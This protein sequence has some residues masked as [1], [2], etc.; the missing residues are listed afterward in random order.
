MENYPRHTEWPRRYDMRPEDLVRALAIVEAERSRSV[1]CAGSI[2]P[3]IVIAFTVSAI[4]GLLASNTALIDK[5][6]SLVA[7]PTPI[8]RRPLARPWREPRRDRVDPAMA[9]ELR[10]ARDAIAAGKLRCVAG[11]VIRDSG[12]GESR[13]IENVTYRGSPLTCR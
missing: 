13:S 3:A 7:T 1:P 5:L 2:L 8:H 12:T 10:N 6:H 11:Y 4:I 9:A